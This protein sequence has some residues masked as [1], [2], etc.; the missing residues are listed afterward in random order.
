MPASGVSKIPTY[1]F[2][3]ETFNA[4]ICDIGDF[5]YLSILLLPVFIIHNI[6]NII[7]FGLQ[8]GEDGSGDVAISG[9]GKG[10]SDSL[11][12]RAPHHI[13]RSPSGMDEP[14]WEPLEDIPGA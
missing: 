5:Y 11:S 6:L 9:E 14:E 2:N 12:V 3:V 10:S 1:F 7:L 13:H 8:R 4:P